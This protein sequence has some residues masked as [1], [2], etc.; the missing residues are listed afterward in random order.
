MLNIALFDCAWLRHDN[1]LLPNVLNSIIDA[2]MVE[3]DVCITKS[4]WL[5]VTYKEDKQSVEI[6]IK[7]LAD[8]GEYPADLWG[9]FTVNI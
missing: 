5:G 6:G 2:E 3:V 9:E 4:K 7:A 1:F 8:A